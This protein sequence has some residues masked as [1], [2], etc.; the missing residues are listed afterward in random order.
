MSDSQ[1]L[2]PGAFEVPTSAGSVLRGDRAGEGP[3]VV[4][5]HGLTATRRMVLHGSRHLQRSGL[6]SIA[7]DARGHG[8]SDAAPAGG[9]YGFGELAADL[10]A[11]LDCQCPD[12]PVVLAGHSMGAHTAVAFAL[13]SPDRV[14]G[15]VAIGPATLGVSPPDEVLAEWDELADGLARDGAEGFLAAYDD[16]SLDPDWRETL[17]RLARER[18][19]A[20]RHPEAVAQALRE[21]PRSLPFEGMGELEFLD[22]PAL[23]VASRDEA[24]P[25]HPF[26]VAEA[27]AEALPAARLVSEEPGQSP[28]AWQGGRLSREIEAFCEGSEVAGRLDD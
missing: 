2:Q 8:E 26:A 10:E 3:H 27:W 1:G 21:V 6:A 18:L 17:L 23:V 22:V 9:G 16:G 20:H 24:D 7:Y 28:L 5:L 12:E 15:L 25:G 19:T 11:V 14:A 4:Q 13:A